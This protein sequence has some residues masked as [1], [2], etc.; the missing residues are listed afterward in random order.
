[1]AAC[2]VRVNPPHGRAPPVDAR[3]SGS[4]RHD[5]SANSQTPT[6]ETSVE[7]TRR[8]PIDAA[9]SDSICPLLPGD[10]KDSYVVSFGGFRLQ[11]RRSPARVV[12][13]A[14]ASSSFAFGR[15]LAFP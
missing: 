11:A 1:M 15:S 9:E 14:P 6:H 5:A 13:A 10:T 4:S 2:H 12:S 7:M 8:S 3:P